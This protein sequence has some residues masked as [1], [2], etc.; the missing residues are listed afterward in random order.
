M[1]PS[2][3]V[4]MILA[5]VVCALALIYL[6][7][8]VREQS[9]QIADIRRRAN[10]Q[11]QD[12]DIVNIVKHCV[13]D[14]HN[15]QMW[16]PVWD[17]MGQY[18]DQRVSDRINHYQ[19]VCV[20]DTTVPQMKMMN[21]QRLGELSKGESAVAAPPAPTAEQQVRAWETAQAD[22]ITEQFIKELEREAT[23]TVI[24]NP[25]VDQES[26]EDTAALALLMQS[27][28]QPRQ[29]DNQQSQ[30]N[31]ETDPDSQSDA[32]SVSESESEV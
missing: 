28:Q 5:I 6:V 18:I 17:S 19:N 26:K 32:G 16:Q 4:S 23:R 30:A 7:I 3:T 25:Q 14:S 10:Q 21:G 12:S 31:P 11:I 13:T 22:A 1:H 8:R 9:K 2:A 20:A 29:T 27:Q 24:R 15:Q